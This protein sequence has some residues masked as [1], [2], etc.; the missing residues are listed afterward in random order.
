MSSRDTAEKFGLLSDGIGSEGKGYTSSAEPR[1]RGLSTRSKTF[2]TTLAVLFLLF[3]WHAKHGKPMSC[4][5][6][7]AKG[8]Y[9]WGDITPTEDINLYPCFNGY[10]CARLAVPLD[11]TNPSP[12][13]TAAIAVTIL[14]ATDTSRPY[15]GPVLINPGGPGGSGVNLV[16]VY[17]ELLQQII[18]SHHSIVS[19][20]PRGVNNT[21]PTFTC[22]EEA[23]QREVFLEK[24]DGKVLAGGSEVAETYARFKAL[25]ESCGTVA[26]EEKG[27]Y[28]N[29][30]S[31]ARDMLEISEGLWGLSGVSGRGLQYWGFSYGSVLGSTFAAMFP[32][33]VERVV[34]DGIC[35]AEDYYSAS[36]KTSLQDTDKVL[37]SFS[38]YCSQAGPLR[39]AFHTGSTPEDVTIR[40]HN[41]LQ[42]L[43]AEPLPIPSSRSTTSAPEI[44]TESDVRNLLFASLY[45]PLS[46]FPI[47]AQILAALES[48]DGTGYLTVARTG[49]ECDCPGNPR[50]PN[51]GGEVALAVACSDGAP[52]PDDRRAFDEYLQELTSQTRTFGGVWAK[53]RLGCIN[54]SFRPKGLTFSGPYSGNTSTPMLIIGNT[55]DPVTPLINAH[56]MSKGFPGSAVL[57][58][59]SEGHCSISAPSLCTAK[60]IR[61]YFETG[62][63]PPTG[64]VCEADM[65]PFIGAGDVVKTMSAEDKELLKVLEE[66]AMGLKLKPLFRH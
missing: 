46:S 42:K 6:K 33:K 15:G 32:E 53:L 40:L 51:T 58:Q 1:S 7:S 43:S 10:K 17:G 64:T 19:F 41:L 39:C 63:V 57:E 21:T 8:D 13:R 48:G 26:G 49:F 59:N 18:G 35:D 3:A 36:W 9:G 47:M 16:L 55:R 65:K 28:V 27:G 38:T 50:T 24:D 54:W 37:A 30:A 62:E 56:T 2:L 23:L 31:V 22:F 34:V 14:E 44:I 12:D 61:R 52:V 60:H 25:S 29:T 4:G 11:Y 45:S 5:E 66:L 20:D